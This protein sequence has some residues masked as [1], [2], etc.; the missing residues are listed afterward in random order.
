M[1]QYKRQADGK[2]HI[3]IVGLGN[4]LQNNFGLRVVEH[5]AFGG[6][7]PGIHSEKSYHY[8]PDGS[9]IDVQDW[10]GGDGEGAEGFNGVG[11]KQRT[12][13]LR[14][15]LRGSG[16]EVIGPGDMAGHETHL[17]LAAD[18]GIFKLDQAQYDYLFGGNAGGK[19]SDFS[20]F[21]PM[22]AA[23]TADP[24][25][26]VPSSDFTAPDDTSIRA[27]AKE[28]AQDY[29]KMSKA[30]LDSAYDVLRSDD[31]DKAEVEGMKMHRA[32]FSI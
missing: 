7:T 20:G 18:G 3:P 27:H 5:P 8:T 25:L 26:P 17:H 13:N 2:Y 32:Y 19:M 22:A 6:V 21:A 14:N 28:L 11:F 12:K 30:D 15:I 24:I 23:S 4:R 9:A 29:S 31:P 10:R 16:A 1:S